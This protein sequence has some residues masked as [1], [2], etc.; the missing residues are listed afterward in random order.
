MFW[1]NENMT[2]DFDWK[3]GCER[4]VGSVA[5]RVNLIAAKIEA[6]N[7]KMA[8]DNRKISLGCNVKT[9]FKKREA[10]NKSLNCDS[11]I[12]SLKIT[13]INTSKLA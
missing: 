3:A 2:V 13:V 1:H 4:K 8:D 12:V 5:W 9:Y 10:K 11:N 7:D 6:A